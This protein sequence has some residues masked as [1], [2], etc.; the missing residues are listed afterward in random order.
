MSTTYRRGENMTDW[1]WEEADRLESKRKWQEAK[2]FMYGEWKKDPYNVTKIVRLG[3]LCWILTVEPISEE[4]N[5]DE[6]ASLFSELVDFGLEHLD[7]DADFL[8]T[9]GYMISLFP[10]FF[11]AVEEYETWENKGRDLIQRAHRS[12]PDDPIIK[13]IY[14]GSKDHEHRDDEYHQAYYAVLSLL[15]ERFRGNGVMQDYFRDVLIVQTD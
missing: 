9:F 11:W 8:W 1:Q 3:F 14:L 5:H 10:E 13:L 15:P 6:Y 2:N 7:H 4:I 12:R